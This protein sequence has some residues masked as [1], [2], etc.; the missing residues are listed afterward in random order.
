VRAADT[1]TTVVQIVD[2]LGYSEED[3]T[4]VYLQ[5]RGAEVSIPKSELPRLTRYDPEQLV[6]PA[7]VRPGSPAAALLSSPVD[8]Q[9]DPDEAR[10]RVLAAFEVGGWDPSEDA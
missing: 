8:V 7:V 4:P 10:A 3:G 2:S 6:L 1:R 9:E 5:K